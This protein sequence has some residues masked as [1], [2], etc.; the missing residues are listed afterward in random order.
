MIDVA[1]NG[2]S[3]WHG[4]NLISLPFAAC[5]AQIRRPFKSK[6]LSSGRRMSQPSGDRLFRAEERRLYE[7]SQK[8]FFT[9]VTE[10]SISRGRKCAKEH[11]SHLVLRTLFSLSEFVGEL[12]G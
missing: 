4:E 7:L 6:D 8:L 3:S 1:P 5:A 11:N 12:P 9:G 10:T 2:T